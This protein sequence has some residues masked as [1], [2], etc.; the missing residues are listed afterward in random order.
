MSL[1]L[2]LRTS[3]TKF[4]PHYSSAQNKIFLITVTGSLALSK[5]EMLLSRS[6]GYSTESNKFHV[7][8]VIMD[9]R[10]LSR[11]AEHLQTSGPEAGVGV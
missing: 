2:F 7:V 5:S 8:I 11:N 9:I 10:L 4:L 3:L 6:F 1:L